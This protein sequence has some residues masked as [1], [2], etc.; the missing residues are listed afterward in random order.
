[1][2]SDRETSGET[3]ILETGPS[4]QAVHN[5]A[6]RHS[7]HHSLTEPVLQTATYTFADTQDLRDFMDAR[8]WGLHGD[9][10]EYGRYGNPTVAAAEARLAAL[11]GAQECVLFASGM[12]A[13][14]STLLTLL[15]SGSH[16]IITDDSYRRTRQF[17]TNFLSRYG[18][19]CSIVPVG[20][21]QALE[22]SIRPETKLIVSESPTNPYLRCLDL[23]K[24]ADIGRRHQIKTLIDSTLATPI[25]L[26]PLDFGIDLVTHSGTKYLGGHNDLLAG[27]I[28]GSEQII[29]L[30][31]QQLWVLGGVLDPN[32]A[33]LLIRGL[34]TL[35]LRISRQNENGQLVAEFLDDHPKI[36]RVWH[37][38]LPS[39]P[40][41]A[42]AQAQ[43]VGFG[44]VVSFEVRGD[45]E[46]ASQLV[47]SVR[48]PLIAPS[49]GGVETLIE[50]P[51]L[52]SYYELSS[53]ERRE[54][55]I[56]ENLIRLS[57]G[58]EDATDIIADLKDALDRV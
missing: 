23:E 10:T 56:K 40:D 31:R 16:L 48:I 42:V 32:H 33:F 14:T 43:M 5:G 52:M 26:Q 46:L 6:R 37:P 34:K 9:R 3:P 30:I 38:S 44:G 13:I 55:G 27:A 35:G 2:T 45:L 18:V 24:I 53:Q 1:M 47:D 50:Q 29:A 17:C 51:A 41:Y 12:A 28:C 19:E 20:D 11:E 58:I 22:A 4:T 54:Q 7:E 57:L 39:H 25:N 21:Y 49:L 8:M 36:S 15:N